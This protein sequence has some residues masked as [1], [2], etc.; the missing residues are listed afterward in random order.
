MTPEEALK[1][2]WNVLPSMSVGDDS[3]SALQVLDW[4]IADYRH[5][6]R[7][8]TRLKADASWYGASD[9]GT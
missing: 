8:V 3:E 6:Q 5:N 2:L 9:M 1:H 7:R 4:A